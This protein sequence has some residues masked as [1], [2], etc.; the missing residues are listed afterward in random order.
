MSPEAPKPDFLTE[1]RKLRDC[2]RGVEFLY[3]L[4]IDELD[5]LMGALK[6]RRSAVGTVVIKQGDKGDAFYLIASGKVSV[7]I[8]EKRI[9]TLGP[10][11]YFGESALVTESP[12]SATVKVEEAAELYVLYKEDF[13]KILMANPTIAASIKVRV[14]KLKMENT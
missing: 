11:Q 6:R 13:K 14:A 3:E 4:K 7:W 8:K 2:L 10:A 12:R 1:V 5:K 9:K